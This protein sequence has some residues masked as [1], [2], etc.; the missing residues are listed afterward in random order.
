MVKGEMP[1]RLNLGCGRD[2]RPDCL[3]VDR[4]PD[5]GADLVLDLGNRDFLGHVDLERFDLRGVDL[6]LAPE[7]QLLAAAYLLYASHL[8]RG[9]VD[10]ERMRAA[11]QAKVDEWGFVRIVCGYPNFDRAW[12]APE[13][14]AFFLLMEAAARD[15][16]G[17]K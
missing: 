11:A 4:S 3:N 9:K 8:S 14:Q 6:T 13:G 15:A 2:L 12:V 1:R 17:V 7:H 10:A 5:V 16:G